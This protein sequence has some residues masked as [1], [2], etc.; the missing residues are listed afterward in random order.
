MIRN[1]N[2]IDSESLSDSATSQDVSDVTP[3]ISEPED[4]LQIKKHKSAV[5]DHFTLN[6]LNNKYDCNYCSNNYKIAKDGLTSSLWK[7]IK[8]NIKIYI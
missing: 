2:D 8:K 1:V 5:Y 3:Q 6:K 7:Y 4:I